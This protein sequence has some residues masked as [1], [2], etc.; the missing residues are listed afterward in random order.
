VIGDLV[1]D[2]AELVRRPVRVVRKRPFSR[3]PSRA[4]A[5]TAVGED[6]DDSRTQSLPVAGGN[7]SRPVRRPVGQI[8]NGGA[9]DGYPARRRFESDDTRGFVTGGDDEQMGPVIEG[10]QLCGC[11]DAVKCHARTKA[12]SVSERMD[13]AVQRVFADDVQPGVEAGVKDVTKSPKQRRLILDTVQAGD[14]QEPP[15]GAFASRGGNEHIRV[16][17]DRNDLASRA[18]GSREIGLVLR[19]NGDARRQPHGRRNGQAP[20]P[21]DLRPVIDVGNRSELPAVAGDDRRDAE[22]SSGQRGDK[23]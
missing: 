18:A 3:R 5:G 19:A 12:Q 17:A 8:S 4:L 22:P 14:L 23:A 9:D 15:R 13:G 16:H 11:Q 6:I 10:H 2:S 21:V 7:C 20:A 1:V